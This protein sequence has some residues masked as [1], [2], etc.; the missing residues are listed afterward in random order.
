MRQWAFSPGLTHPVGFMPVMTTTPLLR[1]VFR[2]I[3]LPVLEALRQQ[4]KP[5]PR[6]RDLKPGTRPPEVFFLFSP[7]NHSVFSILLV[8]ANI[9]E[10]IPAIQRHEIL[11]WLSDI[12]GNILGPP[13]GS[14]VASSLIGVE[15]GLCSRRWLNLERHPSHSHTMMRSGFLVQQGLPQWSTPRKTFA[16]ACL[17]P[18]M[19]TF[20]LVVDHLLLL[21]PYASWPWTPALKRGA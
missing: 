9:A 12:R 15:R 13:K 1:P 20:W 16:P 17:T 19:R 4:T 21:G 5:R 7:A 8:D 14:P 18:S 2:K 10:G 11:A 3:A 6:W